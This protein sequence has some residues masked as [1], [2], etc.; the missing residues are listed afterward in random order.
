LVL[1]TL[2]GAAKPD[3]LNKNG[4]PEYLLSADAPAHNAIELCRIPA[5]KQAKQPAFTR[6]AALAGAEFMEGLFH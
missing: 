3:Y 6:G 2:R 5:A 4:P 1:L